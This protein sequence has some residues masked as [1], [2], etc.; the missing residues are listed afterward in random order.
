MVVVL[1]CA[2]VP[3]PSAPPLLQ[4]SEDATTPVR[5]TAAETQS[6]SQKPKASNKGVIR[7][8]R[9]TAEQHR[10]LEAEF[11]KDPNWSIKKTRELSVNLDLDRTKIYKWNYDRKRK[12]EPAMAE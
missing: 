3:A 8:Q 4:P 6:P 9:L 10:L 1:N 11:Q 2:S 12:Q 5:V 7:R